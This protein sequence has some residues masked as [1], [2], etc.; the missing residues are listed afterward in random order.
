MHPRLVGEG[1]GGFKGWGESLRAGTAQLSPLPR[2]AGP[3]PP[4]MKAA[5][6]SEQQKV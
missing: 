3:G 6:E 1:Q 4:A 2:G 5:A